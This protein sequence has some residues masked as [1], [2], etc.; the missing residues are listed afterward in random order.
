MGRTR[1]KTTVDRYRETIA[2]LPGDIQLDPS[3]EALLDAA[4]RALTRAAALDRD[5]RV[6]RSKGAPSATK[7]SQLGAEC[8]LQEDRAMR[9]LEGVLDGARKASDAAQGIERKS[10]K[11]VHAANVRWGK[12]A[13]GGA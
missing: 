13:T 3:D 2:G 5:I 9:W 11:H 4:S 10:R 7:L 6:E 12:T 8:R 1:G